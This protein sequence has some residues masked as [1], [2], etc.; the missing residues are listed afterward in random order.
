MT[1]AS[2]DDELRHCLLINCV[3]FLFFLLYVCIAVYH[4]DYAAQW[5]E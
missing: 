5:D 2:D 4:S 3:F 1:N